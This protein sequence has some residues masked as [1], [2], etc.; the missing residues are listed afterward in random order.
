MAQ[1]IIYKCKYIEISDS[2]KLK[3]ELEFKLLNKEFT[4]QDKPTKQ[5]CLWL[6]LDGEIWRSLTSITGIEETSEGYIIKTRGEIYH[7]HKSK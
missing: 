3:D 4:L 5:R 6:N 7:I 2:P 1:K